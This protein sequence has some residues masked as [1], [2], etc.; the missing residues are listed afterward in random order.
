MNPNSKFQLPFCGPAQA[1]LC[2]HAKQLRTAEGSRPAA[3]KERAFTLI[4]MLVAMT[5]GSSIML[6]AVTLVHTAFRQQSQ[7]QLRLERA[8]KMDRF[9][10]QF[11]RDVHLAGLI[12]STTEQL[13]TLSHANEM[14]VIYRMDQNRLT[15]QA[16]E[17]EQIS[18]VEQ[19]EMEPQMTVRFTVD[20][21]QRWVVFEIGSREPEADRPIE[22]QVLVARGKMEQP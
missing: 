9:V 4:E 18:Q 12:E 20:E 19:I 10:E 6:T 8:S 5:F 2:Q 17:S 21:S 13:L 11:R 7:T 16:I 14:Q 3:K 1:K 22:R 15:R